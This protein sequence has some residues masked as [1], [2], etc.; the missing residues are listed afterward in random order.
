MRF[1]NKCQSGILSLKASL[2]GEEEL[3]IGD[4]TI[5]DDQ[6]AIAFAGLVGALTGG[7]FSLAGIWIQQRLQAKR[8]RAKFATEIALKQYQYTMEKKETPL[9]RTIVPPLVVWQH[10]H[11]R[12]LEMMEAGKLDEAA[13][14]KIWFEND[15]IQDLLL[16][17]S[18]IEIQGP[19]QRKS[20]KPRQ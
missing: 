18:D 16:Q 15:E 19:G 4:N 20:G 13:L 11:L 1:A 9:E 10:L 7:A 12:V 2:L 8:E 17:L 14:R 3:G 6:L 5:V